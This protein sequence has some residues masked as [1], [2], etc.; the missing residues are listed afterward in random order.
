MKLFRKLTVFIA[1]QAML[2]NFALASFGVAAGESSGQRL[3]WRQGPVQIAIS[4][5][6]TRPN[7]N[8]KYDTDL[9]AVLRRSI[10]TWQNVV[11][12]EI[13]ET[14]SDKLSIS[15]AGLRGDGVNILTIAQTAENALFF[16]NGLEDSAAATRVFFDKRGSIIEAD[17]A[18][19]PFQQFSA[20]GTVGTFD[21]ESTITHEIGHMLGLEHSDVLGATMHE[22]YGKNGAYGLS[23][24]SARTLSKDDIAAV[25]R[26]YGS[27]SES[28]ACCAAIGGRLTAGDGKPR[29]WQVWAE[30]P[31]T[32]QVF[33]DSSSAADGTYRLQGLSRGNYKLFAQDRAGNFAVG[34]GDIGEVMANTDE[35]TIVNKRIVTLKGDARLQFLGFNGQLSDVA[36]A[37]NRG[38]T[39]TVYLGGKDLDAAKLSAG[40]NSPYLTVVPDTL[41][42]LDFGSEVSVVTFDVRIDER[43]PAGDYSVFLSSKAGAKRYIVGGLT[44]EEY[45]NPWAKYDT[46]F[47]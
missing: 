20:D 13:V 38:K 24:F 3:R 7:A 26:L 47:R 4:Q 37:L 16:S 25:Q 45:L 11:D 41:R 2:A 27:K 44:V 34:N 28:E 15:P 40:F 21:L 31:R 46:N 10:R 8:I 5:S 33:T 29:E 6:M 22:R 36:I 39:Y 23:S 32:G 1:T 9:S 30:D 35:P 12:I 14:A 19:N 42:S 43:T 17:I 18:L